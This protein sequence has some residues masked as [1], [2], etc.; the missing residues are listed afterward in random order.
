MRKIILTGSAPYMTQ[1]WADNKRKLDGYEIHS[2]N[3]SIIITMDKCKKWWYSNDFFKIHPEMW[4]LGQS[5][6]GEVG[7]G[8]GKSLPNVQPIPDPRLIRYDRGNT[9]GTSLFNVIQHFGHEHLDIGNISEVNVVGCDL[10][11][12]EGEQNHFYIGGT[13]DP[14]RLGIELLK[15]NISY[16]QRE[17]D[18]IGIKLYNLSPNQESLLTFARKSLEE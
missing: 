12:K 10:I 4:Q 16:L 3:M 7:G 9:S 5:W 14:M 1:W 15:K 8:C 13:P 17:Y 6:Q 11:Y 18:K 2:M